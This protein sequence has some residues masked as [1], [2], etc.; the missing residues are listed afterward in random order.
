MFNI[1]Q[2]RNV[3]VHSFLS[4]SAYTTVLIDDDDDDDDDDET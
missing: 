4:H 3:V 1:S 2:W